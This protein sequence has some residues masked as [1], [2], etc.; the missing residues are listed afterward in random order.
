M[1]V[2]TTVKKDLLGSRNSKETRRKVNGLTK[3]GCSIDNAPSTIN[4]LSYNLL[5]FLRYS[6]P[7]PS[8]LSLTPDIA[9]FGEK[10]IELLRR[11]RPFKN[12]TPS[13]D[14]PWRHLRHARRESVP[15][16]LCRLGR[17]DDQ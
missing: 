12:G 10:K 17:G 16:L 1:T 6:P 11:F 7:A 14:H 3:S 8:R 9:R 5:F 13:H 4:E 15:A 2:K